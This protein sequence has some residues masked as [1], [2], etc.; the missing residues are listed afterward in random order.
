M[1]LTEMLANMAEANAKFRPQARAEWAD[2]IMLE[3]T[4]AFTPERLSEVFAAERE[5]RCVVLP[6][7]P[8]DSVVPFES[9]GIA[10]QKVE[11]VTL[12]ANGRVTLDFHE[13][14]MVQKWVD[15]WSEG[16]ASDY[17]RAEAEEALRQK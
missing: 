7:K 14:R 5:G 8:G 6:V 1:T 11:A 16:D 13:Y 4:E 17:T 3:L 9:T 15:E 12:Y 2:A 10:P